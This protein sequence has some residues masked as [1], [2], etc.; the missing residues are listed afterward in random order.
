MVIVF[1]PWIWTGPLYALKQVQI[2]KVHSKPPSSRANMC[3][4]MSLSLESV[5][6]V[7]ASCVLCLTTHPC[8]IHTYPV[9]CTTTFTFDK[10]STLESIQPPQNSLLSLSRYCTS[11]NVLA[12]IHRHLHVFRS[13]GH[14]LSDICKRRRSGTTPYPLYHIPL[15][16]PTHPLLLQHY[17]LPSSEQY[18]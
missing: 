18:Y 3:S 15:E 4:C 14:S 1:S 11:V 13:R 7:F 2:P 16:P 5:D 12:M 10:R 17:L 9:P 8:F 6:S